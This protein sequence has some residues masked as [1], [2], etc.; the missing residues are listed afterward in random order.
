MTQ[1]ETG[2]RERGP[3]LDLRRDRG[4]D[5]G[6]DWRGVGGGTERS[7]ED[8][9]GRLEISPQS[10]WQE[11]EVKKVPLQGLLLLKIMQFCP[12]SVLGG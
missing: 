11:I 6:R 10:C 1:F 12:K 9:Q 8:L 7:L 3:D 5:L 4:L 2:G